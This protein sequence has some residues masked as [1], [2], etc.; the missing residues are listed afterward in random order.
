M[1][2]QSNGLKKESIVKTSKIAT[3][4]RNL[5]I[6]KLG[7]IDFETEVKLDEKLVELFRI[8]NK[9]Q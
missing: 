5:I 7:S 4:D 9:L 2:S 8:G 6:G 3:I 1:P